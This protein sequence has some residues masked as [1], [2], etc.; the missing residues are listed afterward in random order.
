MGELEAHLA[1]TRPAYEGLVL[2]ANYYDYEPSPE[3]SNRTF[4]FKTLLTEHAVTVVE[5]AME[6]AG[7]SPSFVVW[8]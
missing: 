8:A 7:G 4:M 2:V 5:K 1:G 3:R 6:V